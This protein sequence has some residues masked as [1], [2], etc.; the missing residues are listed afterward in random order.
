MHEY[1]VMY[2]LARG[3]VPARVQDAPPNFDFFRP[4][5]DIPSHILT[6]P[7]QLTIYMPS[8]SAKLRSFSQICLERLSEEWPRLMVGLISLYGICFATAL[9]HTLVK[10]FDV[11][12]QSSDSKLIARHDCVLACL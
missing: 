4:L 8:I 2:F 1:I 6:T 7:D 9:M 10:T 3:P 12:Q 11:Q 5:H